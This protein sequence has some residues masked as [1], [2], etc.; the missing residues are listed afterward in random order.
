MTLYG[1]KINFLG[2]SI[3]EGIGTSKPSERFVDKIAD[4][5]HAVCRNYGISG[6]R[7]ARQEKV[8]IVESFDLDFCSRVSTMD[9]DADVVVVF[10]GT[11]DFGHGDA[12]FG[13]PS[14]RT[15]YTFHGALHTLYSDLIQRFPFATII[16]VTPLHR[17]HEEASLEKTAE[18]HGRPL[19]AYVEAIR[20]IAEYYSFPV[21]DLYAYGGLQPN[22][23]S[24]KALFFADDVHPNDAG[25]T[26]IAHKIA[27]F[28]NSL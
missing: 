7:I 27:N 12:N 4:E 24:N 26:V 5:Y 28:I 16:I 22:V 21:L 13:C 18:M 9:E 20:E 6:T 17:C 1:L 2:D 11:N 14:D 3:T 10:G 25:H 8:S 19:R 15:P 23:P